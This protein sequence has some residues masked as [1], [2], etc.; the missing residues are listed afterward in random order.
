MSANPFADKLVPEAM[1]LF[2]RAREAEAAGQ[3]PSAVTLYQQA[4]VKCQTAIKLGLQGQQ[5]AAAT[6]CDEAT[7]T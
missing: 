7:V 3:I 1:T 2:Q 6:Q 5:L 4:V